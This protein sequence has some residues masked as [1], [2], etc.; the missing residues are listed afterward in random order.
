MKLIVTEKNIAAER[1][2][3]ILGSGNVKTEK[4]YTIPIY[5]FGEDG[6]E[7]AVIGLKGHILKVDFP[8]EYSNWQKVTPESLIEAKIVKVPTQKQIIKALQKLA[9]DADEVVIATDFDREGELIGVDA[10]NLI[11]E[12]NKNVKVKRSRFSA[13]TKPEIERAFSHPEDLYLN[14]ASAGEAR[15]DIDLIWGATLTRFISLA[16]KRYGAQFLSV[17]RVQSPTLALIAQR[18]REREAFVSQPYWQIKAVFDHSDVR[19]FASHKTEKFWDKAEAEAA[20]AALQGVKTGKVTSVVKSQRETAPP[21]PFNT[22]AFLSAAAATGTSTANAMRI[23]ESLYMKGLISYPRVDN[24]V[25][26]P[27]LD[28]HAI[29]MGLTGS[30]ELGRHAAELVAQKEL[31]P[32]RGK[33]FATDHPPIHPTGVA[34]NKSQLDPQEWKIYELVARRFFATLAQPAVSESMRI[35]ID[36]NGQPFFARGSLVVVEGWLRYYP[37]SR[38]KDEELPDAAEGDTVGLVSVDME[39][40]ETQPPA[41]YSQAK[42]IQ[43]MEELGLGTKA[44]RHEIIRNLYERGYTH[45]DPIQPTETGM[46]VATALLKY[47]ERIATPAMTAELEKEMNTIAEGGASQRQVVDTSRQMLLGVMKAL[48]G[49][50]EPLGEM[51]R[52]GI[53]EDRLVGQCTREGCGGQ[54]RI[55]KSKKTKKRFIGCTNYFKVEDGQ[56]AAQEQHEP[57]CTVAYPL[58]QFGEI[59]AL[60]ETCP[61]C[62]T[63]KIKVVGG[64]RPWILCIDPN[65]PTKV[66]KEPK[67]G[68]DGEAKTK[69]AAKGAVKKGKAVA[70]KAA[71]TTKKTAAKSTAKKTTAKKTSAKK[72][73]TA[74][75]AAKATA[76]KATTGKSATKKTT[77]KKATAEK[78]TKSA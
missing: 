50:E 15:Q 75:T 22:T 73:T 28:L 71:K 65:C 13:I 14:L 44:T 32:T 16:S 17:G 30:P 41:R 57:G 39:D 59:I 6:S 45:G 31:K 78:E 70:A 37:Y 19:F 74:A 2:A 23:A 47:A 55:M 51:I 40:K 52:A 18:E 33:K 46:A 10:A 56:G 3:K 12:A 67:A 26:P 9:K 35:D 72:S 43:E 68:E 8:E 7:T 62:G 25:Y 48:R 27:S 20:M 24:T 1:I 53:R 42:L 61:E 49:N 77:T 34:A 38:R 58:P 4:S 5:R 21:A 54:L 64:R 63:P 69:T 11:K 36:A 66:K 60:H 76:A 29:L